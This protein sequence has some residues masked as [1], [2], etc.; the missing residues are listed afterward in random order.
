V[1]TRTPFNRLYT[2]RR[3][4][5][6]RT[7][8]LPLAMITKRDLWDTLYTMTRLYGTYEDFFVCIDP[9]ETVDQHK[10]MMQAMF[11][12]KLDFESQPV[13]DGNGNVWKTAMT[14][15]ELV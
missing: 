1:Q 3:G 13:F 6:A 11:A 5:P 2:D 4:P 15:V 12:D 8:A 10:I 9:G 7:M 14:L